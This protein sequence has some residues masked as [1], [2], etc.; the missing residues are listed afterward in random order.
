MKQ[1]PLPSVNIVT[2]SFNQGIFLKQTIESV[3]SQRDPSL[4]YW[5]MDG[6]STDTS[7]SIMKRYKGKLGWV[8]EKDK[9]QTDAINK[10]IKKFLTMLNDDD[11]VAYINSDDYYMPGAFQKVRKVFAEKPDVNWVVGDAVIVDRNGEEIQ[12]PIRL[13]KSLFRLL[14][15]SLWIGNPYPQPSVFLRARVVKEGGLFREDLSYVMDYE[16]W[17]R[18]Q[19]K[20]GAPY[21]LDSPLSSFRIHGESKGG[22]QY[23]RQF[24][25]EYRVLCEYTKNPFIRCIH[26]L[27]TQCILLVYKILKG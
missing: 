5:V 21:R 26:W 19:T 13:Y 3:L 23:T 20:F 9:G 7:V 16:Y 4:V 14:P 12:K 17:L 18:T 10:G 22:S 27:H 8:S 24:A 6:G 2:P 15:F 25:E 11:I 1:A